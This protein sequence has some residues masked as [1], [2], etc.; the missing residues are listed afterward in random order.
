MKKLYITFGLLS[1]ITTAMVSCADD[2]TSAPAAP[3]DHSYVQEFDSVTAAFRQGWSVVNR[4]RPLGTISWTQFQSY[5][6]NKKGTGIIGFNPHSAN[7]SG[8]DFLATGYTAASAAGTTN[9]WLISP[10]TMMK[11]GDKIIFYSAAL[12]ND[13]RP[14]RLQVRLN[15]LNNTTNVGQD[16]SSVGDF[17]TLLLSINPNLVKTG[18]GAY[19]AAWTRY[20]VTV[21]GLPAPSERRFAFRYYVP[22]SGPDGD[23]GSFVGIDSVAFVS[24]R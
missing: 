15:P 9:C 17:Q 3:G 14:D 7:Y 13:E 2:D 21:A 4:S 10:A 11:N 22:T 5:Y 1:L 8:T 20:E 24:S 6:E 23:N 18:T 16:S 19:P 12:A